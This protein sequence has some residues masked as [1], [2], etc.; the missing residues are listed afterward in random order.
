[1]LTIIIDFT[2][3]SASDCGMGAYRSK[4]K[5]QEFKDAIASFREM[6]AREAVIAQEA[7]LREA[8]AAGNTLLDAR[9][10]ERRVSVPD[11]AI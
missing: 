4:I 3:K 11:F 6:R 10:K 9:Q 1:M 5:Q 2:V 8:E 7:A